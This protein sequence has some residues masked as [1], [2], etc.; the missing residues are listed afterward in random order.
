M[1]Y[2]FHD[3]V[4][5]TIHRNEEGWHG[6]L[7]FVDT[8]IGYRGRTKEDFMMAFQEAVVSYRVMFPDVEPVQ[9]SYIYD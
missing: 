4:Y 7:A 3:G 9:P 8:E 2:I 6:Q 1:K 5:G